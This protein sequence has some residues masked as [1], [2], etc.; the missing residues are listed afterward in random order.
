LVVV[1]APVLLLTEPQPVFCE[2]PADDPDVAMPFVFATTPV[3]VP[4]PPRVWPIFAPPQEGLMFPLATVEEG[5]DQPFTAVEDCAWL[6]A[7]QDVEA[8]FDEGP[9]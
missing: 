1:C 3:D 9:P 6:L 8:A 5:A 2:N 7:C 4:T